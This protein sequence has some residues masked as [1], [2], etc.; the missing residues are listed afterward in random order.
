MKNKNHNKLQIFIGL[1]CFTLSL[2][3]NACKKM[4]ASYAEYIKDGE[5]TYAHKADSL[6]LYSG[7]N[8]VKLSWLMA[9]DNRVKRA[10]IYWNNRADSLLYTIQQTPGVNTI[11]IEIPN[12][13]EGSYTFEVFTYDNKGNKSVKSDVSGNV[14]GMDYIAA[15]TN[16][17]I[18]SSG[19]KNSVATIDWFDAAEGAISVELNYKDKLG[20]P[21]KV[22]IPAKELKT[23][24]PSY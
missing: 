17:R 10:V 15:L 23:V 14:Y 7:Q 2:A 22:L 8:R 21:Q 19:S 13:T 18:K 1:I 11:F 5:I 6:K 3:F 9:N 24:L 20:L 4:D 12:L 16:R